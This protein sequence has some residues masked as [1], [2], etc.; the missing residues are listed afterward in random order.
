MYWSL[1]PASVVDVVVPGLVAGLPL[2]P[3]AR[4]A[5]F[6]GRAAFL[7]TLYLGVP[8]VVLA[9]CALAS[10]RWPFR[11]LA[12]VL[13]VAFLIAA[14][15][16]FTPVYP[17]L[18]A[19]P[20]VRLLRYPVKYMIPAA[21]FLSLLAGAGVDA[22]RR[23]ADDAERKRLRVVAL[24]AAAAALA[25][26]VAASTRGLLTALLP[27]VDPA[28]A[29]DVPAHLAGALARAG[30]LA[31]VFAALLFLAPRR[32]S[33]AVLALALALAAAD[34][35]AAGRAELRLAPPELVRY[36]PPV[37]EAF[38]RPADHRVFRFVYDLASYNRWFTRTP[39]GWNPEWAWALGQ[40][41]LLAPP[42]STRFGIAGSFDGD[43]TGLTPLPLARLTA[44]AFGRQDEQMLLRLLRLGSVT[45]VI[46]FE[47]SFAGAPP[48]WERMSVFEAPVRVFAVPDPLPRAYLV[49]GVVIDGPPGEASIVLHHGFDAASEVALE[50]A[51]G[52]PAVSALGTRPGTARIVGRR[53]DSLSIDVSAA[54]PAV[55]VVTES[56]D[57]GW[58]AWVDGRPAPVWRANAIFRGV[59]VEP[60]THRVEMRYRPPSVAWGAA[61]TVLGIAA[62][63]FLMGRRGA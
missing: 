44:I 1:H 63:G 52:R 29:A 3:P 42:I 41:D 55:L 58:R 10:G 8:G 13:A 35:F 25:L 24:A 59:A 57:P 26:L 46:S 15:G 7:R 43:F 16:R 22:V 23:G 28:R 48:R 6:E 34:L 56:F 39:A 45:D 33:P 47:E 4:E 40:I 50:A 54:A 11:W 32:R 9:A 31:A 20:V 2:A 21:L 49:T 62:M 14:L 30:L 60:G 36:V 37:L 51:A 27:Y 38:E 5:L 18:T 19:L 12:A 17:A 61:A 53:S